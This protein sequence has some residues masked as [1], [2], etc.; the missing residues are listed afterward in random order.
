[1]S[2]LGE[3]KRRKVFQVAAVY[4][5]VAWLSIQIVDVVGEPLNLPGWFDTV[6]IVLFAV[7]FP[8]AVILAWAFD[9]TPQGI[10][11]ASD[12]KAGDLPVRP[13][14]LRFGYISQGL[15][16]LAVG[17]LV[18][19]QYVLELPVASE[20]SIGISPE[21]DLVRRFPINLGN[22]A[23]LFSNGHMALS[24]DGEF[25]VYS[26]GTGATQ[27]YLRPMASLSARAI[28]GTENAGD[29]F[30]S[31]DGEWVAFNGAQNRLMKTRVRGGVPQTLVDAETR[32]YGHWSAGETIV[33]SNA[34]D[35]GP[36]ALFRI[37]AVGGTSERLTSPEQGTIH[38]WPYVLP[39]GKSVLF[40]IIPDRE[41]AA[42]GTIA[43]LSMESGD[44]QPL[45]QS[46]FNAR[47]TPTGHL[48]FARDSSLWAV[49]F[50]LERLETTGAEV[51]VVNGLQINSGSGQAPYTFAEDGLLVYEPGSDEGAARR[52]ARLAWVDR[53]GVD[54]TVATA[55]RRFG[56]LALSPDSSRAVVEIEGDV[57]IYNL[58]T[59]APTRLTVDGGDNTRPMWWVHPDGERVVFTSTEDQGFG[60]FWRRADGAGRVERLLSSPIPG[61][62]TARSFSPDGNYLA[63]DNVPG[64]NVDIAIVSLAGEP[65]VEARIATDSSEQR[66]TIS[67]NGQWIAYQSD[68]SGTIELHVRPFPHVNAG[69]WLVSIDDG[70]GTNPRWAPDGR[71][72]FYVN[73]ETIIR[74]TVETEPAFASG[75]P[76]PLFERPGVPLYFYGPE[77]VG[78]EVASDGERFLMLRAT[79]L[80][81]DALMP[82]QFVAVNNWFEELERLVPTE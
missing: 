39:D 9:L 54:T 56:A 63:L 57:W 12:T 36:A 50:D 77:A 52:G 31:P 55:P 75:V 35:G 68:E 38:A 44:Y 7:G 21:T 53:R 16:L 22:V 26:V 17:F 47:Y 43:V 13:T 49:P 80:D 25:L 82:K 10:R 30:V 11:A 58:E 70:S 33:F 20:T 29:P 79:N 32:T 23:D 28:P 65:V 45:V 34:P 51:P 66:P 4:A 78:F 24:P 41:G 40:T 2:F 59:G 73:G 61:R 48:V 71:E 8:I 15:I 37:S 42:G 19:D 81:D 62:P 74:T 3:I 5:V 76:E 1:M 72:L 6:V 67:P 60:I 69:N 27:L 14:A 46:A 18:V 64:S